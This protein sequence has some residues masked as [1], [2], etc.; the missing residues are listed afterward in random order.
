MCGRRTGDRKQDQSDMGKSRGRKSKSDVDNMYRAI[1]PVTN[2]AEMVINDALG[3]EA[4]LT[5][6]AQI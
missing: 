3:L 4:F 5:E 1:L 6:G 2:Q